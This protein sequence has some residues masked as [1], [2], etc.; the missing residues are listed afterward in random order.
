[1]LVALSI[2]GGHGRGKMAR[3]SAASVQGIIE[4]EASISL[5][6]FIEAANQLVTDVCTSSS[7]TDEKLELIERWLAAHFYAVRDM[8]PAEE[9]A[10]SVR[11]RFQYRVDLNLAV[12]VYGQQ[13]MLLDTAG[14][15]AALNKRITEGRTQTFGQVSWLGTE[16]WGVTEE[17]WA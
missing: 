7:Y 9:A 1:L 11:Q 2:F 16:N 13:A 8:R 6:P 10:G 5:T 17:A 12:T 3:T 14:N 15:L 4:T